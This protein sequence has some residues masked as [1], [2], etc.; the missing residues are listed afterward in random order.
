MSKEATDSGYVRK[1]ARSFV[2][3]ALPRAV[4]V[5]YMGHLEDLSLP[6][7]QWL[8]QSAATILSAYRTQAIRAFH[9]YGNLALAGVVLFSFASAPK[10]PPTFV[11]LMVMLLAF[12]IRD[13]YIYGSETYPADGITDA[14]LALIF[15]LADEALTL[16]WAPALAMPQP[17]FFRG[18]VAF[19][20]LLTMFR[21]LSRPLPQ[22][23]PNT[24]IWPGLPPE[25]IYWKMVRF[26]VLW[27]FMFYFSIGMFVADGPS[28]VDNMRGS[29][30]GMMFATWIA[31]QTNRLVRRNFIQQLETDPRR[32]RHSR[33]VETL[34]QGMKKGDPLYWWYIAL[35]GLIFF[36][37]A[38][39]IGVELWSW[40]HGESQAGW[41]R[42]GTS[43]I[44]FVVAV[45][46]W[47]YVKAANR[48]AVAA[49][50]AHL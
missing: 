2:G 43:L 6:L 7:A 3:N 4:R 50:K 27:I 33:M 15:L 21:M 16:Q 32:L 44:A 34:P 42:I 14:A 1:F 22:P 11:A 28:T 46:A 31:C 23:D 25:R 18:S 37:G 20:A 19:L 17:V 24:P 10:W 41:W 40:L 47:R 48:A 5:N 35:E 12:T 29:L 39:N 49:I 30:L 36:M 13:A 9:K 38:A 45:V 8:P 26:N